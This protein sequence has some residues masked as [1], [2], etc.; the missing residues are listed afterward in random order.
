L[1]HGKVNPG[2]G[3]RREELT[4]N[5]AIVVLTVAAWQAYVDDTTR[6]VLGTIKPPAGHPGMVDWNLIKANATTALGR[7]NTANSFNSLALFSR[8]G[9]DPLSSWTFR[10]PRL[11]GAR[12]TYV[13]AD[14]QDEIDQWLGIRHA[15][16][17]GSDLPSARVITGTSARGATL[18]L[19]D[20]RNCIGSF[21]AV[22]GA[23][24]AEADIQFP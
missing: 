14:A 11:G 17:H 20:A 6:A 10:I 5:R 3:R 21:S 2:R 22:V 8:V 9:F 4:L 7:F 18:R 13:P 23:T 1:I 19:H 15:I 24:A 16:A 12:K